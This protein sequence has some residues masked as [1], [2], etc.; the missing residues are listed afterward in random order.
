MSNPRR[1]NG[2]TLS[3]AHARKF[4]KLLQT[5]AALRKAVQDA[6]D[7]IIKL[8]KKK[9]LNVSRGEIS[10]A[11]RE[12]WLKNIDKDDDGKEGFFPFSEKP[13]F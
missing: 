6:G 5:D 1:R 10:A 9:K 7:E 11:I 13:G 3:K 12:H 4:I 8:A 2:R